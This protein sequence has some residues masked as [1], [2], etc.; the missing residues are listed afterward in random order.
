VPSPLILDVMSGAMVPL[1]QSR[2]QGQ[3]KSSSMGFNTHQ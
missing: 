1:F 2:R 3:G